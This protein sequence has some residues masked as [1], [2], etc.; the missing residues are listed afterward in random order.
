MAL[1]T[2]QCLFDIE[3]AKN[4]NPIFLKRLNLLS[5]P[6]WDLN[7]T[8]DEFAWKVFEFQLNDPQIE[9][10]LKPLLDDG[11]YGPRTHKAF[12]KVDSNKDF[13]SDAT[14]DYIIFDGKQ[15]S[16]NTRV[17]T[18][19]EPGGMTFEDITD[20]K[21]YGKRKNLDKVRIIAAHHDATISPGQCFKILSKRGL[22]TAW[23]IDQDGTIYQFFHD[24]AIAYQYATG[25]MNR[26]SIPFDV[27]TVADPKYAYMYKR[28]GI[29]VPPI[30]SKTWNGKLKKMLALFPEQQHAA[31]ELIK[32][33]TTHLE[34]P[35]RIPKK[36]GKFID[37]YDEYVITGSKNKPTSEFWE[38]G[39]GIVGHFHCSKT[40]WDPLMFSWDRLA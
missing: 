12:L 20:K 28:K 38:E 19:N 36:G 18:P 32:V 24:P 5:N 25:R 22:S 16:I 15:L 10:G 14:V 29:K 23:D 35:L 30:I 3:A 39:G 40:K 37:G 13:H 34:I 17:I 7:P 1:N 26:F 2:Q 6:P 31:L 21:C 33:L 27:S 4:L 11:I 9:Y 8:S